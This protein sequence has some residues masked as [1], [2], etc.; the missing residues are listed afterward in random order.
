VRCLLCAWQRLKLHPKGQL[1]MKY[2]CAD[3]SPAEEPWQQQQQQEQHQQQ[4]QVAAMRCHHPV[5]VGAA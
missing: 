5:V 2:L 3:A 4:Q 1:S